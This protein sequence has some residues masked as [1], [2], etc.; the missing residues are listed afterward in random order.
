MMGNRGAGAGSDTYGS[1]GMGGDGP[2][3]AGPHDSK[4][5]NKLDPRVDSDV[6]K[7][8]LLC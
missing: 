1:T 3:N 8:S 7:L 5:A 6:G 4:I 2:T